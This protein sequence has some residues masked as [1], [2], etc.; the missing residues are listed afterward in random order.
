MPPANDFGIWAAG[1][2]LWLLGGVALV[3]SVRVCR[4]SE[5][6][7]WENCLYLPTFL[8]GRLLW[9][10]HFTNEAPPEIT[11]GAVLVANHRSSVD[12]F[13]VQ[14]AA[15][16]RVHWMVAKEYCDHVLFGPILRAL[17]VIPTNRSGVDTASTKAAIRLT[18]DGRLVGMFPEGRINRT[19][20]PLLSIRSGAAV[21][22]ARANVPIVPLWILGSP[23]GGTVWSPLL[24]PARVEITFGQPIFPANHLASADQADAEDTMPDSDAIILSWGKQLVGL[25]GQPAAPVQ[26]ASARR[27]RNGNGI[28]RAGSR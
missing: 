17:Q 15:G 21:V 11:R 27:R 24:M 9:R 5:Y 10:V 13:F 8:M 23:Y 26:L 7:L 22:A 12:P 18:A 20:A 2:W 1:C 4:R 16:R 28:S 6:S 3:Y 19:N 14:L 25:A